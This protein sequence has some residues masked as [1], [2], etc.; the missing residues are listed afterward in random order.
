M[1]DAIFADP[2]LAPLYDTFDGERDDLELYRG[3]VAE[4]GARRV[5]DVGCGTGALAVLL[6]GEGYDVVGVD[7][8]AASLDIARGKSADVVWVHGDAA[9]LTDT[10]QTGT[11]LTDTAPTG[12]AETCVPSDWRADVAVMTGNVAQVFLT[13]DDWH[14]TLG[15][16]HAALR[17]GGWFVFETRRPEARAWERW[18]DA[19]PG[20]ATVPGVGDVTQDRTV[21]DVDLPFVSF[22]HTYRFPDGTVLTSDSTL[23][24]RDHDEVVASLH[25]AGFDVT[26]VRDAPDRPGLERVYLARS[27]P[28]TS[29]T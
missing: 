5:L 14:A 1:P 7:P 4:V 11:V 26:D 16:I 24:F 8:A 22:R 2:R 13:D 12:T 9:A 28:R 10:A 25:A 15:A 17:P 19:E 3:I 29:R 20:T 6:A 27:T 18:S 23:R 21:T